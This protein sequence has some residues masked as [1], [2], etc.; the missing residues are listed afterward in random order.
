M[1]HEYMIDDDDHLTMTGRQL[2][3]LLVRALICNGDG[4]Q[5]YRNVSQRVCALHDNRKNN[6]YQR[7]SDI[8]QTKS[9]KNKWK[10][11]R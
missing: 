11:Y 4:A 5:K 9:N 3:T 7:F 2:Q 6:G 8:P 10:K 1:G